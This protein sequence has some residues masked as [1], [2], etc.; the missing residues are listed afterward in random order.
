MG[1]GRKKFYCYKL[2]LSFWTKDEE[3]VEK[4][5]IHCAVYS[6]GDC[7]FDRAVEMGKSCKNLYGT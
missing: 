7:S 2:M 6:I 3:K 1:N 5:I 4:L